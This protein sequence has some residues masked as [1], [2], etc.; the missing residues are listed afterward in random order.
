MRTQQ[1]VH[2]G[3][4]MAATRFEHFCGRLSKKWKTSLCVDLPGEGDASEPETVAEWLARHGLDHR[5]LARLADNA[6]K[7]KALARWEQE[8]IDL[9][10]RS[11]L[12]D[13]LLRIHIWLLAMDGL[14]LRLC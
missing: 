13:A 10:V 7:R 2:E 9:G 1:V 12:N 6:A 3:E 4:E 5:F 11:A 8:T 14:E